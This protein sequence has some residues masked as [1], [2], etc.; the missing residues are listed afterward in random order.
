MKAAIL[1]PGCR[2]QIDP[3]PLKF[4]TSEPCKEKAFRTSLSQE[5]VLELN[6][7]SLFKG[8]RCCKT[9]KRPCFIDVLYVILRNPLHGFG[10][11]LG[12]IVAIRTP[13]LDLRSSL[14]R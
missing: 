3:T 7:H 10:V 11:D 12:I 9:P 1:L 14:A 8:L 6:D 13:F 2:L 4:K 5:S